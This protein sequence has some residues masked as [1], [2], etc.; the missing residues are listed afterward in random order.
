MQMINIKLKS[1]EENFAK[2]IKSISQRKIT[3]TQLRKIISRISNQKDDIFKTNLRSFARFK[4]RCKADYDYAESI[5]LPK[6]TDG[7]SPEAIAKSYEDAKLINTRLKMLLS[8]LNGMAAIEN[9]KGKKTS[10]TSESDSG[11]SN[12]SKRGLRSKKSSPLNDQPLLMKTSETKVSENSTQTDFTPT[13]T[14]N[15]FNKYDLIR[16]NNPDPQSHLS[17]LERLFE[18]TKLNN[19]S[20]FNAAEKKN[21]CQLKDFKQKALR[22]KAKI[23]FEIDKLSDFYWLVKCYRKRGIFP[24]RSEIMAAVKNHFSDSSIGLFLVMSAP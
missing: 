24:N 8:K 21:N 4:N 9:R 19:G 22:N 11:A 6:I 3:M 20:S 1:I 13:I 23:N 2:S 5:Q 17:E 18:S 7:M 14:H 15:A 12:S 10:I 16:R